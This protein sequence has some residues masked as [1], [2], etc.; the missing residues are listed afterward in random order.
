[1]ASWCNISVQPYSD[2]RTG[3]VGG[4]GGAPLE[5]VTLAEAKAH[6]RVDT[7]DEDSW[8]AI[9]IASAREWCEHIINRSLA[10][11]TRRVLFDRFPGMSRVGLML[12][13][14][15]ASSLT[16]T[17]KDPS[18]STLTLAPQRYVVRQDWEYGPSYM[19]L[20]SPNTDQWPE[21]AGFVGSV[22]CEYTAGLAP[23]A[24]SPR[25][26]SAIL[27]LVAMAYRNR[28]PGQMD[29][30]FEGPVAAQVRETLMQMTDGSVAVA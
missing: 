13:M 15:P 27:S 10:Q 20:S 30:A 6:V 22:T 5:P 25:I 12:P 18:E 4:V 29:I 16:V 1:M 17:Y 26:K 21:T 28:E 7:A 24:T 19:A 2:A 9:A 14:G 11:T 23:A 3:Y 8:F